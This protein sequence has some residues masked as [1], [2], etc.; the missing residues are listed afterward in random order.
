MWPTTPQVK[1]HIARPSRSFLVK[2]KRDA[3]SF[4]T[5]GGKSSSAAEG[6]ATFRAHFRNVSDLAASVTFGAGLGTYTRVLTVRAR[7]L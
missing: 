2:K 4:V 7:G 1:L 5:K 3:P 6:G